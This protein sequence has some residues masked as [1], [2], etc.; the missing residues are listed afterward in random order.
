MNFKDALAELNNNKKIRRPKWGN[1]H[2]AK[3]EDGNIKSYRLEALN[4]RYDLDILNS[5]GW[6][7]LHE[8][9]LE[10]LN[11]VDIIPHL[12]QHKRARFESWPK[13]TY[14]EESGNSFIMW[15]FCEYDFK[16]NFECFIS[17][18]WEVLDE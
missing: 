5:D 18:D 10:N 4:F 14:I 8:N 12:R 3:D 6:E 16:P 2:L 9:D 11:F 17:D 7:I 13:S 1:I 15:Q